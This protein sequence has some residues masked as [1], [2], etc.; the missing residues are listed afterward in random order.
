MLQGSYL[1]LVKELQ[2]LS[3]GMKCMAVPVVLRE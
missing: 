2:N 1:K 3:K